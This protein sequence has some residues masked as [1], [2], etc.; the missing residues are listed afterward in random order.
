MIVIKK[1]GLK[2]PKASPPTPS[3]KKETFKKGLLFV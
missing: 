2:L 1:I 3:L